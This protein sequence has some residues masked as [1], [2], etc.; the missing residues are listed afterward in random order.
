MPH[1]I[2]LKQMDMYGR[3]QK[4]GLAGTSTIL[5]GDL[6]DLTSGG[7]LRPFG[8]AYAM[9]AI[10]MVAIE[11]PYAPAS[12]STAAIDTLYG[13]GHTVFYIVPEAGDELYM[14]LGTGARGTVGSSSFLCGLGSQQPGDIGLGTSTGIGLNQANAL[15]FRSLQ[16]ID[17]SAGTVHVRL[18]VEVVQ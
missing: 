10:P 6:L 3:H 16:T 4:E 12:S 11:S 8:T 9:N 13:S 15:R 5:P 7:N 18:K 2:I 1:T 14:W 17:N